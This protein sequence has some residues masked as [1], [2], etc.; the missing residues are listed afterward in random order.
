MIT[1]WIFNDEPVFSSIIEADKP[2]LNSPILL[3]TLSSW[4]KVHMLDLAVLTIFLVY[5]ILCLPILVW[6]DYTSK[7]FRRSF[8]ITFQKTGMRIMNSLSWVIWCNAL[9]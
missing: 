3:L 5:R 6:Y 8:V 2:L 9:R 7:G 1:S 4:T